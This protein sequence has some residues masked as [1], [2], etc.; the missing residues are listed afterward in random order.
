MGQFSWRDCITGKPI[1]D[2][3]KKWCYLLVPP[4]FGS[5]LEEP[6][7]DGYGHFGGKDVYDL[8]A[9]WN[10]DMIPEIIRRIKA[11]TWDIGLPWVTDEEMMHFYNGEPINIPLRDIGI[12]MAC[13]DRNNECLEYPIKVTYKEGASYDECKPSPS[14]PNQGW[15]DDDDE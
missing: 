6:E 8:V 12:V 13:D 11:G 2:N 10:K 9:V 15:G 7:Y 3:K 4:K 1:L 5:N 14:D